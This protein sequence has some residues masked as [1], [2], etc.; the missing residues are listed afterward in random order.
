[1]TYKVALQHTDEGVSI[2]VPG[3]PGC[4]SQGECEEEALSNI[5][6][7]ILEYLTVAEELAQTAEL[8]E[9]EVVVGA[10]TRSHQSNPLADQRS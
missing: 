4:W 9:V 10:S 2:W 6:S 3:L 5:Q 7:A 8:R 1:M